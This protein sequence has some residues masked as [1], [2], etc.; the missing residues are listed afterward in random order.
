MHRTHTCSNVY[1][2][3]SYNPKQDKHARPRTVTMETQRC[4]SSLGVAKQNI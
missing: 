2:P 4:Y 3:K 1:K